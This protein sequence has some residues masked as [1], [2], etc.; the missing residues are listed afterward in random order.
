RAV[1]A[2]YRA[3]PARAIDVVQLDYYD[4]VASHHLRFPRHRWDDT[5][6]PG[7]LATWLRANAEPGL[8][9]EVAENGLCN[10]VSGSQPQ[11]RGDGWDRVRFLRA[12]LAAVVA[13][14]EA[15][16]PVTGYFHWTLADSYEWGSYQPRYGLYGVERRTDS[17]RLRDT[18]WF[19]GDAAGTYR[20]FAD[21]LRAGD[22]DVLR[23]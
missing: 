4:P 7:G 6:H 10:R 23:R 18:D 12:N 17:V 20:R 9:V 13:S 15:G 19:G 1:D 8:G 21:G 22:V 14:L 11:P 3:H 2:A 5:V 16:V